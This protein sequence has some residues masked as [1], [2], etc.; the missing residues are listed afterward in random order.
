MFYETVCLLEL[1]YV[2]REWHALMKVASM[3]ADLDLICFCEFD[4]CLVLEA[5]QVV[6]VAPRDR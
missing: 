5:S 2:L 3:H 6:F 4:D 1:E